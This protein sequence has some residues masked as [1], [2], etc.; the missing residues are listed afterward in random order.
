MKDVLD[1]ELQLFLRSILPDEDEVQTELRDYAD[2][3][4]ISVVD[5]EVGYLLHLLTGLVKPESVLEIGTAIGCSGI[6]IARAM[7]QGSLTTIELTEERHTMALDYF[8]RAG[9]ADKIHAIC[10]DARDIVPQLDTQY[11][12]IFMDAAKGQYMEFLAVADRI[13]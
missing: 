3:H 8:R 10:G 13:L 6:Y 5:P 7:E 12:M 1:T 4:H 9:V 11:D 2:A